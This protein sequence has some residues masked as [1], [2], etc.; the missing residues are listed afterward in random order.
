MRYKLNILV[1]P[2]D[3]NSI[4]IFPVP[5]DQGMLWFYVKAARRP[6]PAMVLTR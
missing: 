4:I 3:R 1:K 5:K 6:P 2:F